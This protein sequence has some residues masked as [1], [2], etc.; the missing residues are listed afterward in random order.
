MQVSQNQNFCSECLQENERLK[1]FLRDLSSEN[2]SLKERLRT[3]EL[4][5]IVTTADEALFKE[6]QQRPAFNAWM[7]EILG[8]NRELDLI[9]HCFKEL[10]VF[11][12]KME[13]RFALWRQQY[14]VFVSLAEDLEEKQA[15][16]L[17]ELIGQI[18]KMIERD[19]PQMLG[20]L[21]EA[22]REKCE[23]NNR[24]QEEIVS[25]QEKQVF[26]LQP[27]IHPAP[28]VIIVEK[29]VLQRAEPIPVETFEK[30]RSFLN[31]KI[32]ELEVL[33]E[34][35]IK[36]IGLQEEEFK[37]RWIYLSQEVAQLEER[38]ACERREKNQLLHQL[39]KEK[40][41]FLQALEARD[42][43]LDIKDQMILRLK[44]E[45]ERIKRA[46]PM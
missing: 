19:L 2:F 41:E 42:V 4:E 22:L 34:T 26:S 16:T 3:N 24:L 33:K 31:D 8:T 36:K 13:T 37:K 46:I 29:K 6:V 40:K 32:K 5:K 30:E 45:N 12:E 18:S 14:G 25:L 43:D 20:R 28:E 10:A 21:E 7:E 44:A 23:A 27:I 1:A 35:L 15:E 38:L 39:S 11:R 9:K 17:P